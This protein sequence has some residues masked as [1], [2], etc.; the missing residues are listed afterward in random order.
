M[1]CPVVLLMVAIGPDLVIT[2]I[3]INT[4]GPSRYKM[5]ALSWGPGPLKSAPL[6]FAPLTV[7]PQ[8]AGRES[9]LILGFWKT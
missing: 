1:L 3:A 6:G 9:L 5:Q 8:G 7:S 2:T 4:E